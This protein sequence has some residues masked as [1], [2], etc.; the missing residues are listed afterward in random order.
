[1]SSQQETRP[2]TRMTVNINQEC[3]D[4]INRFMSEKGVTGTE[5]VRHAIGLLGFF[6]DAQRRGDKIF[7]K[8][9]YGDKLAI[10]I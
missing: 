10:W 5:A 1:M 3:A 4:I 9:S 7:I 2:Y 8:N 6:M